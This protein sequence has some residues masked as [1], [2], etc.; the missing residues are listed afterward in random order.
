MDATP[1]SH[2]APDFSSPRPYHETPPPPPPP[3]EESFQERNI[4]DI[5]MEEPSVFEYSDT[6]DDGGAY[7]LP[8]E[9]LR[10]SPSLLDSSNMANAR[11]GKGRSRN[12]TAGSGESAFRELKEKG[13]KSSKIVRFKTGRSAA[14]NTDDEEASA[15]STHSA[16]NSL[17]HTH[18]TG[19]SANKGRP[20]F[21]KIMKKMVHAFNTPTGIQRKGYST[22][23]RNNVD[24]TSSRHNRSESTDLTEYPYSMINLRDTS[25]KS[26]L[27]DYKRNGAEKSPLLGRSQNRATYGAY[28]DS[29]DPTPT[30]YHPLRSSARS[31]SDRGSGTHTFVPGVENLVSSGR[32]ISIIKSRSMAA[33][34]AAY[35]LMD[36]EASRIAA[37]PSTFESITENQLA[38][39]KTY[40]SWQWRYFVNLAIVLLFLSHTLDLLT[41]AVM[42]S[43]VIV[44]LAIEIYIREGMYGV[45]PRSDAKHPDRKFVRPMVSF[46]FLLGLETWMWYCFSPKVG[47]YAETPPLF[48][49]FLKP[50]VLFYVSA[51][52]RDSLEAIWRIG[53]I[54]IRVLAIESFLILIFA[55]FALGIFGKNFDDFSDLQT[56]WLSLFK[57]KCPW[58]IN[59]N[60]VSNLC[61]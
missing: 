57:R 21:G 32:Q 25:Q 18:T 11:T 22:K 58:K 37:L 48:S 39:Y 3:P 2:A 29:Y 47:S 43:C 5:T 36:Y 56:S 41:T 42:H 1:T 34:V 52:A 12:N 53:R 40:Y 49:S 4:S 24:K 45:D 38:L 54:V 31:G 28:D 55:A 61:G 19:E 33:K 10:G 44:V 46:L 9:S 50:M 16:A 8:T 20:L 13:S 6:S 27:K 26:A 15:I 51:K 14:G 7:F 30:D 35:F 23:P 59:L 17:N 60:T